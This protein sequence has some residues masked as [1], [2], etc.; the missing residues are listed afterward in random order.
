M[1][2]P[3]ARLPI[4]EIAVQRARIVRAEVGYAHPTEL[5]IEVLAHIR[6]VLV[7]ESP[8]RGARANLVR[9][10]S[11]GVISVAEGL[12]GEQRRWAIAHELGHFETHPAANYLGLC[13][14]EDLRFSYDASG[15]EPEANAFAAELLMPEDLF[16]AR[17]DV[18]KVSWTPIL[19]LAREFQVSVTA[20]ALRFIAFTWDRVAI[21]MSKDGKVAWSQATR[22]FGRRP[23]RG[24]ALNQWSL[25]YD[26][27][28]KG[29]VSA[30]PETVSAQAWVPSARSDEEVVEHVFPMRSLGVALSILWFPAR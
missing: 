25:A 15:H 26:F 1:K 18:A 19:A 29:Q 21:V 30:I 9:V 23:T 16:G 13:V 5:E 28:K 20:A 6:G 11:R 17:C 7:R 27:F 4:P 3:S 8:T 2:S 10:G 12:P 22:D 14:G 24:A